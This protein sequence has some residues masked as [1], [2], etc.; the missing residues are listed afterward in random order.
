MIDKSKTRKVN[1]LVVSFAN[2]EAKENKQANIGQ[3]S[4]KVYAIGPQ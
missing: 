4:A 3:A 1:F 2:L